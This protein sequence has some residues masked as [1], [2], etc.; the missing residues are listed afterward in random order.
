MLFVI[1]LSAF[2]VFHCCFFVCSCFRHFPAI[3]CCFPKS[4]T[5]K[6]RCVLYESVLAQLLYYVL[7]N[8]NLFPVSFY[9]SVF[10]V[11]FVLSGN[12][13][14]FPLD[15]QL[16]PLWMGSFVA[17]PC[18]QRPAAFVFIKSNS[19]LREFYLLHT[20]GPMTLKH[21]PR[22]RILRT[23]VL[24]RRHSCNYTLSNLESSSMK[25]LI[26]TLIN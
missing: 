4:L 24:R 14:S 19:I 15:S 1:F 25:F 5:R 7:D 3:S 21:P 23:E 8:L 22:I 20:L 2:P 17:L 12:S 18:L 11:V 9:V 10:A 16:R 6:A 13:S 26:K